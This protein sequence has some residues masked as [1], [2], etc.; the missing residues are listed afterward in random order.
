MTETV[1]QKKSINS[2]MVDEQGNTILIVRND[3]IITLWLKLKSET[4]KRK[5]GFVN[6]NTKVLY[7]TRVRE[8]HLFRKM[9]AYGFCYT[10]LKD[11]KKFNQIRLKDDWFEWLIPVEFI[12]NKENAKYLHFKGNGG[13]ELQV[14]MSLETLEQFK[15]PERF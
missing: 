14:F 12:L 8:K 2:K 13:F 15:R 5:I 3:N 11:A 6:T 4:R 10:I 1:D 7:I 9:N